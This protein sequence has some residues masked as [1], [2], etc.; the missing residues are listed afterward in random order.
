MRAAKAVLDW[1]V[2][3]IVI[4]SVDRDDVPDGGAAHFAQTVEIL[5]ENDPELLVEVRPTCVNIHS[6]TLMPKT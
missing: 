4:T 1:G 2:N 3:Y 6:P 5:K